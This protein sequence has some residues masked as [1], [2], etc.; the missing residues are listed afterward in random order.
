MDVLSSLYV[1]L[2]SSTAQL[3]KILGSRRACVGSEVDFSSH[4]DDR[5]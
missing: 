2:G 4:N 5:A 1:S 3:H